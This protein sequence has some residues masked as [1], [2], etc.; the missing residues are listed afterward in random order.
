MTS[1]DE[2]DGNKNIMTGRQIHIHHKD[3]LLFIH[4]RIFQTISH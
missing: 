3:R 1:R 2:I 4:V